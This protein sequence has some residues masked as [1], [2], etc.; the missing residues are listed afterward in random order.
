LKSIKAAKERLRLLA[1][2]MEP[3]KKEGKVSLRKEKEG[4]RIRAEKRIA[5]RNAAQ[6]AGLAR[7]RTNNPN[8]KL[9]NITERKI[10]HDGHYKLAQLTVDADGKELKR[11]RFEP[12][13]AVAALVYDTAKQRYLFVRQYRV[14]SES[15]LL[16]IAAGVLDKE[17]EGPEEAIRREIDEE[18][19]Y[20]VD[21]LE[22]IAS[23]YASPGA[24]AEQ[25]HLYYAEVSQKKGEGGGAPDED[26][27]IT[28]V[29]FTWEELLHTQF[30]D[31]KT[32]VATQWLQ[33][34]SMQKQ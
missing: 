30:K 14:G 34:R 7:N 17:G 3:V 15:E 18:L 11:E 12:G 26:E 1:R 8:H 29:S 20:A 9:M 19:G 10:L 32:L 23:F 2:P 13:Q 25:I 6:N 16:E 33:L 24:S 4:R 31:A 27:N 28:I 22:P 21:R 5:R